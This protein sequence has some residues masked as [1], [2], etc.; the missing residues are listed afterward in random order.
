[1]ADLIFVSY[2]KKDG[3]LARRVAS[4][5]VNSSFRVWIDLSLQIGDEWEDTIEQ[6]IEEADTMIVLLSRNA[7]NSK[8]VM[9]ETSKA[10]A[11]DKK[12]YPI[13]IENLSQADLPVW[14]SRIQ[15][16]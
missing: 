6:K 5:L 2:S 11:K 15:Y 10:Y 4:D 12:L 13:L 8:W 7:L 16:Y 14:A 3:D 1:M 9:Y